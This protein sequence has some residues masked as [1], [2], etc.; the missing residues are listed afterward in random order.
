MGESSQEKTEA[1]TARRRQEARNEGNVARSP[2][3]TAAL[4]LLGGML[5][6]GNFGGRLMG[7]MRTAMA[8]ILSGTIND[9]PVRP[10]DLMS[11]AAICSYITINSVG[12]IVVGVGV[13][14]LLATLM[15]VGFLITAKPLEPSLDKLNPLRGL[16]NLLGMRGGVRLVMSLAKVGVIGTVAILII[17]SDLDKILALGSLE[18]RPMVIVAWH[19]LYWLGIK[20]AIVLVILAILDYAYQRWQREEDMKMTKEEIKEEMKRMDGDPLV[21]QRRARVARQLAMQR[22]GAAVP[23]ADVV[24]TNP[25]HFAIALKYDSATMAAPKVV[26]KGADYMALR[27]RQLAM[28]NDVPL[29]ERKSLARSLYKSV[30][31][32]QEVPPQFFSAIAEILAY[33]Y[34]LSGK[35][36]A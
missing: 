29:V 11:L 3:L 4:I 5:L 33:V 16:Q 8:V 6:L 36:S 10:G 21:K 19:L 20:L 26:A 22:V 35:R 32:G 34:R 30:E 23:Q 18:I 9:H 13:V 28:L 15:Q 12:P 27:I 2:D 1:P 14:A 31:V 25:T 17:M 7:G 24:V